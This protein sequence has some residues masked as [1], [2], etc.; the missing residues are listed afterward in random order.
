MGSDGTDGVRKL[1]SY[2]NCY[3]ITQSRE[4]CVVYGMPKRVYEA[5]LSDEE[6]HID[7][8]GGRIIDIVSGRG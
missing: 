6:V 7:D 1:K 8:I 5:G 2:L 4:S 3:C